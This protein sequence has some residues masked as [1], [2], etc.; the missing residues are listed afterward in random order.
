M[1]RFEHRDVSGRLYGLGQQPYGGPSQAVIS[2]APVHRQP[3]PRGPRR[4]S[5]ERIDLAFAMERTLTD[6][7]LAV[8][9]EHYIQ[10][11]RRHGTG[12][13]RSRAIAK[14]RD[15]LNEDYLTDGD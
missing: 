9:R 10:G 7:E 1:R 5:V 11:I 6:E 15:V 12:Q 8:V 3:G 4:E 2:A 13:V 14:I